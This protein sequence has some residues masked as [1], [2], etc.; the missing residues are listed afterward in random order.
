MLGI[1]AAGF[2]IGFGDIGG[3]KQG[4]LAA[5]HPVFFA[6]AL[7]S[8]FEG[9]QLTTAVQ[10]AFKLGNVR[11]FAK[12]ATHFIE[13]LDKN[14]QQR[15]NLGLADDVGLLVDIEQNAL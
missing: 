15:V 5:T 12:V 2:G 8:V 9:L 14:R 10:L 3:F 6:N 13:D 4:L 11:H 1:G 7:V